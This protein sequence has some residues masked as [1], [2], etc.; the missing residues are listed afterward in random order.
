MGVKIVDN[1]KKAYHEYFVEEKYEVGVELTG[2]EVKSIRVSGCS[3]KESICKISAG[4]CFI[5]G[6]H[7]K[8]YE[9]GNIFNVDS[10]R[11]RKLLLH[12]KEIRKIAE[13]LKLKG[14][15]L[16]PLQVYFK[17][18]LIKLEIGLCKGKKL[19]DKRETLKQKDIRRNEDRKYNGVNVKL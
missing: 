8:P 1:N 5:I 11:T 9:Q 15:T 14:Y 12:K 13:T 16:M 17:D 6:M 18:S 3:I 7:I 19:Y 10:D 2:T 4:E